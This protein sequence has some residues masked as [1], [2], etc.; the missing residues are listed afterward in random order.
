MENS[1]RRQF[2][3]PAE[4]STYLGLSLNTIY[5]WVNQRRIPYVKISRLVKFSITDIDE[6]MKSMRVAPTDLLHDRA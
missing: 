2:L 1:I 4:L 5:A 6:W 3:S